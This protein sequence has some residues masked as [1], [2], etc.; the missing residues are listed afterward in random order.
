[1]EKLTKQYVKQLKECLN[2]SIELDSIDVLKFVKA[3]RD[4]R[5]VDSGKKFDSELLLERYKNFFK[6]DFLS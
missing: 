4:L 5:K 2:Y 6:K 3:E 1:M